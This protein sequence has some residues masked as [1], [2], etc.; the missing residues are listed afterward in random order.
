MQ[1]DSLIQSTAELTEREQE[2]LRLVAT[3]TSN[4]DIA[5]QLFISSNTVK[6]HLRNIFSKL[7]VTSRTEAAMYAIRTGVA[8]A[9]IP[10][11]DQ[12]AST[13]TLTADSQRGFL[14]RPW[15]AL[16][17]V[18]L[19][20]GLATGMGIFLTGQ[21]T[22]I[23]SVTA[24]PSPTAIPRWKRLADMPT[25][26]NGLAVAVY[27]NQIYAIGGKTTQGVTGV[28]EQYDLATDMWITLKFK[29]VPVTEIS[30]AVIG[31]QIYVPGGR[32]ASGGV[33]DVLE[34]YDPRRNQWEKHASLPVAL[35]GYALAAFEGNLYI[36]GGWDGQEF[37]ASV[38]K[39]DP[40]QDTWIE[41]IPMPTA[42][43]FAGAATAA[44]KIYVIGG[45]DGKSALTVNEAYTPNREGMEN[46]WESYEP[47]PSIRTHPVVSSV[48]DIVYIL[49]SAAPEGSISFIAYLPQMDAWED[50]ETPPIG[51]ENELALV[52][53]GEYIYAIGGTI[54]GEQPGITLAYRALY[55]LGIPVIIK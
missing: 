25:A 31:G 37:L 46:P 2:I 28:M 48:A 54:E 12:V 5:R 22:S 6:V 53:L 23:P 27:E 51:V 41:R 11:P 32:L 26:R 40:D 34:S 20:L 19:A 33:T 9:E 4:K 13:A 1:N 29:P 55:T 44:G 16:V 35:S 24:L 43:A 3:G 21:S 39:Y 49:G 18:I 17:L 38:Y 45:T 52:S 50:L 42:R 8:K 36:F 10:P 15:V 47:M 14:S 30:A 7:G